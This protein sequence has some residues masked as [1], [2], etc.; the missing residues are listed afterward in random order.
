MHDKSHV[1]PQEFDNIRIKI[2][3]YTQPDGRYG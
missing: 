3:S 2:K 1:V